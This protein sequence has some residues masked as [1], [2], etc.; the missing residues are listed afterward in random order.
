[1][2]WRGRRRSRSASSRGTRWQRS[3]PS[4]RRGTHSAP[5]H[6]SLAATRA[7]A[8]R[9]AAQPP[10][11]TAR[12]R[13]AAPAAPPPR[14]RAG[15]AKADPGTI[16][17]SAVGLVDP[18]D[19]RYQ[20][21]KALHAN[22]PARRFARASS[23][24]RRSACCVD[25][26]LARARTTTCCSDKLL[27]KSGDVR[28]HGRP[29]KRA[30]RRQGRP[31]V[32]DDARRSSTS[33]RVQKSL[34]Q[35][36]RDERIEFIRAS[37]DPKVSVRIATR[38]A[39]QP[40]APPQ[41]SPVAENILKERIK[42]FG[43][44]TW[45]ED[46]ARADDD[47]RAPTSPS[48]ARRRSSGCRRGSPASGLVVTKYALNVVDDQVHRPRDRRGDLLQHDAADRAWAAGPARRRR[49]S[50]I[51][52][53]DRRRVLARLLPPA[54]RRHRPEGHAQGRRP[55]RRRAPTTCCCAS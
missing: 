11:A 47:P 39:D 43:F 48:T 41:P 7:D 9:G 26:Q 36:S 12:R 17:I 46:G 38:D 3:S 45:S 20:A 27:S 25:T 33:R 16:V 50:A 53:Q 22:R 10:P 37:G 35:M 21:D 18:S 14:R 5:A 51:G 44:R 31:D 15:A 19:P 30:A 13:R 49:C 54:R 55:A 1:M 6:G 42:S 52:T 4:A 8:A 24:R 28:H 23:S 2:R 40:D 32:D 34:N 29:R